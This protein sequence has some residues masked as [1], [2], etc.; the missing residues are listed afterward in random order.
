MVVRFTRRNTLARRRKKIVRRKTK[1]LIKRGKLAR[2]NIKTLRPAVHFFTKQHVETIN[3]LSAG[4]AI[5][6]GWTPE[7]VSGHNIAITKRHIYA[8]TSVPNYSQFQAMFQRYKLCAVK[9][10][11]VPSIGAPNGQQSATFDNTGTVQAWTGKSVPL[12]AYVTTNRFGQV[13]QETWS[14]NNW[15]GSQNF[16]RRLLRTKGTSFYMPL[17]LLSEV[18]APVSAGGADY[19][20]KKP[21]FISM[22]EPNARHYGMSIRLQCSDS[23]ALSIAMPSFTIYTKYYFQCAGMNI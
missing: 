18:D 12:L 5:P 9:V 14:E 16:K 19:A 6:G 22:S 17:N 13:N 15:L 10:T 1:K 21:R 4:G 23:S 20:L 2:P 3:F 8:F 7:T 11:I